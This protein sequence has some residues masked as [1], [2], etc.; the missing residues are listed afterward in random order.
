LIKI[1]EEKPMD[2]TGYTLVEG[3]PGLGLVGTIAANYLVEKLKFDIYGHIESDFFL[4]IVRIHNGKPRQPSTIY[5]NQEHKIVVVYSEQIIPKTYT[6]ELAKAIVDWAE[7]RGIN[8]IISLE[9]VYTQDKSNAEDIY[10]IACNDKA[11]E[12]LQKYGVK[13][14][15]EGVTSGVSSMILLE[16]LKKETITGYCLLGKVSVIEDY[17][18]AAMCLEKLASILNLNIDTQPLLKEAKRVESLLT[19][20]MQELKEV[21]NNVRKFEESSHPLMYT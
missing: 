15:E 16:L 1:V 21:H 13:L 20:Q 6:Q 14:V 5:V 9:G 19:R 11:K 18:S 7:K 4:P 17:R 2:L 10:G 8:R 12:E 3:F